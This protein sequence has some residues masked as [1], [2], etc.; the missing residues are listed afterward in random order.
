MNLS[1]ERVPASAICVNNL[2]A[3]FY[4]FVAGLSSIIT[5]ENFGWKT[6]VLQVFLCVLDMLTKPRG[7][8]TGLGRAIERR[9]KRS[10]AGDFE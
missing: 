3:N 7:G 8:K 6:S 4:N 1:G 5:H 9:V 10:F 2:F